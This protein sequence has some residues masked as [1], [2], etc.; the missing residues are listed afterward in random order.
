MGF[1][2]YLVMFF[3][4]ALLVYALV[5]SDETYA[6]LRSRRQEVNRMAKR[7]KRLNESG[8]T[9]LIDVVSA[10][11]YELSCLHNRTVDIKTTVLSVRDELQE[12]LSVKRNKRVKK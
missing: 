6:E 10:M 8:M 12:A 5:H 2:I 1:L 9:E 3:T 7:K 11:R 4:G